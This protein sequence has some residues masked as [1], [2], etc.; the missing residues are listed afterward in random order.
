MPKRTRARYDQSYAAIEDD[1]LKMGSLVQDAIRNSL[2]SLKQRD[3]NL[4]QEVI[5]RDLRINGLRFKIEE[6]CLTLIATQQPTAGDLR[7]VVAAMNI[8]VDM[9]RMADHASGIAKT[10]IRMGDEP[11]LKPLIDLPRMADLAREMLSDA[12]DAFIKRD[13]PAAKAIAPR[14]EEMDL[15]YKA[16]FDEL[17]EIMAHKPGSVERATYLLWCAHNLERIGDR[18]INIVERVIFMT[19][20]DM[21]ELTF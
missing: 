10:V 18:A 21:R 1:I 16:I 13:V 19:T 2:E 6:A 9:E 3:T 20:G 11:L 8:V 14:D 5:D 17:V 7:S 4:A 12:L 15:L